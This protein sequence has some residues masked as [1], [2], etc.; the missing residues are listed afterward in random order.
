MSVKFVDKTFQLLLKL[1]DARVFLLQMFDLLVG[2]S[3]SVADVYQLQK[4]LIVLTNVHIVLLNDVLEFN[5]IFVFPTALEHGNTLI[6]V[7]VSIL[8][9]Q[10]LLCTLSMGY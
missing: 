9:I 7:S 1:L 5:I 8:V 3:H 2:V 10:L 4:L 6:I